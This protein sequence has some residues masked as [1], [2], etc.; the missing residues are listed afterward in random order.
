MKVFKGLILALVI[1][2]APAAPAMAAIF[3]DSA[4]TSD[5]TFFGSGVL[6]GASDGGGAFLSNTFDPPT[7]LG[8]ITWGFSGGLATGAGNDLRLYEVLSSAI[9]Q[10]E[11]AVSADGGV[12]SVLGTFNTSTTSFDLDALGFSGNFSFVRV[13]NAGFVNSP[14]FDS[15]EGFY[16]AAVIPLPAGIWLLLSGVGALA[17]A[18]RRR[19]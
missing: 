4:A 7:R 17:L 14:D 5:V 16:P 8:S 13:T 1:S 12:F 15:A 11:L 18:L 10:F 6:T 9:E 2:A 3:A 19:A